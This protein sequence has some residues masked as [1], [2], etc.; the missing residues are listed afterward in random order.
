MG[1]NSFSLVTTR[2]V[3][4]QD[5]A[6]MYHVETRK[7]VV[8]SHKIILLVTMRPV[9]HLGGHPCISIGSVTSHVDTG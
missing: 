6:V 9:A 4:P 3:V 5:G 8:T 2:S 1:I 7:A